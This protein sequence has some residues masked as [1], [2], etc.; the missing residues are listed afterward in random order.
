MELNLITLIYLFLRL[1]P[2]ILVCFFTLS[3]IIEQNLKGFVYLVGLLMACG[4]N[5]ILG[6][7]FNQFIKPPNEDKTSVCSTFTLGKNKVIS[8]LPMGIC[9]LAYTFAFLLFAIVKYNLVLQNI[10]TIVIFPIFLTSDMIW[11]FANGCYEVFNILLALCIGAGM[12]V[13]WAFIIDYTKMSS[14]QYFSLVTNSEVCSRPSNQT[15]R[16]QFYKK[17]SIVT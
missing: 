7:V 13:L 17:G 12:G 4:L 1:A 11:N 6:S 8:N 14:L 5:L 15:F 3:S 2:F 10:P 16:C 9:T